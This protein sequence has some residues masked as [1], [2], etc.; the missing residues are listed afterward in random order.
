MCKV[1][2]NLLD[3]WS[4]EAV[5]EQLVLLLS[6]GH[7]ALLPALLVVKPREEHIDRP[8]PLVHK[9]GMRNLIDRDLLD[10]LS[11]PYGHANVN[12]LREEEVW[13]GRNVYI[14]RPF[15]AVRV[16]RDI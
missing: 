4:D 14:Q 2:S 7:W 6:Q 9:H 12:G 11:H 16:F 1:W 3:A 15:Q 8:W 5:E 10:L 13:L